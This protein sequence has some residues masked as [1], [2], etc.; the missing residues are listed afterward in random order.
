GKAGDLPQAQSIFD[1]AAQLGIA[2]GF[3]YSALIDA[4]GKAGDLPRAQRLFDQA[5]QL[6]IADAFT[7]SALVDAYGKTG[8]LFRA[9]S[10]FDRATQLGIANAVTYS[11]LVDTYGKAGDLPRAQGLFDQAAQLG[12]AN[13]VTYNTLVD[14]YGKAGD[15]PRAQNIFDQAMQLGIAD[16]VTYNTLVDAYGKAGDLPRAQ[17]LFEQAMRLG[18]GDEVTCRIALGLAAQ[19]GR[20]EWLARVPE[21]MRTP[22]VLFAFALRAHPST[23]TTKLLEGERQ[24]IAAQMALRYR[25]LGRSDTAGLRRLAEDCREAAQVAALDP[26]SR[27]RLAETEARCLRACGRDEE[28]ANRWRGVDSLVTA[29]ETRASMLVESGRD[30]LVVGLNQGRESES[31]DGARRLL[32]GL[33]LA[34]TARLD[35][36][37]TIWS[38][39]SAFGGYADAKD[40]L[41]AARPRG[42]A[43][44]VR[45]I[46]A[47]AARDG[48][49][50]I[51][52]IE[53]ADLPEFYSGPAR[54]GIA[55]L[56]E[57]RADLGI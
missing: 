2:D 9:Q 46:L 3:T 38:L 53:Q 30:F 12:I 28:A 25:V 43:A 29:R 44:R 49:L 1:Q 32:H 10:I 21:E 42:L 35:N 8:D 37:E 54:A 24:S 48:R 22:Q 40:A 17:S 13:A 52:A 31:L 51:Q 4:Y 56:R 33:C 26:F 7:Y 50:A 20:G 47:E 19:H 57:L 36:P 5:T 39:A 45:P 6:G 27:V 15:L 16:A 23:T 55:F 41:A 11:A 14:A 34:R 18:V